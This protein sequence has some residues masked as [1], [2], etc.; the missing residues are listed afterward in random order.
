MEEEDIPQIKK[1]DV[2]VENE[3]KQEVK[4]VDPKPKE[5]KPEVK[6]EDSDELEDPGMSKW[7]KILIYVIVAV[8]VLIVVVFLFR[9]ITVKNGNEDVPEVVLGAGDIVE[10][11][12]NENEQKLKSCLQQDSFTQECET[13]FSETVAQDFCVKLGTKE[14]RDRCFYKKAVDDSYLVLCDNIYD[15]DLKDEC[16]DKVA[17]PMTDYP[18]GGFA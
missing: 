9:I 17:Q 16:I 13:L 3:E 5:E 8:V 1:E 2:P 14:L 18:L 12:L 10:G 4:R 7:I 6:E 15:K 11:D